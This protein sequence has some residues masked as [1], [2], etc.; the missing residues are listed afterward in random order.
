MG[1]I[2]TS[3]A[4]L[5]HPE[6]FAWAGI[7]SGFVQPIPI[8]RGDVDYMQTLEDPEAVKTYY[9][10]FFR[11]IGD[12]DVFLDRFQSDKEFLENKGLSPDKWDAHVERLYPGTHD[13]NVWRLCARDFLSMIF[14]A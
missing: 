14:K 7:F 13:W 6:L 3:V 12:E 11:A 9:K 1:S 2:H 10:L 4:V 8:L 5:R